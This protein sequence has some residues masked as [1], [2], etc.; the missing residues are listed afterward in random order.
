[1]SRPPLSLGRDPFQRSPRTPGSLGCHDAADPNLDLDLGD[2]PGS[3][4]HNDCAD[5]NQD[6]RYSFG[7]RRLHLHFV[8]IHGGLWDYDPDNLL[9]DDRLSPEFVEKAHRALKL[10]ITLYELRPIVHEAYRSPEESDRKHELYLKHKGGKAAPAWSSAHNYGLAMDV[11]LYDQRHHYIDNHVKGWYKLYTK[12]AKACSDFIW[13][14]PFD[15]ADHFEYHPNWPN[16][17]K[18]TLAAPARDW[19]MRAAVQNGKLTEYDAQAPEA[20]PNHGKT[21]R[22][23]IPINEIEWLPYFWW[24]AGAELGATAPPDTYLASNPRPV[25]A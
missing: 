3:L 14:E 7:V 4:G 5:P 16:P 13:G 9:D 1:M 11:W 8:R 24:A 19:A 12:L 10:A 22:D 2:T 25:Q 6:S 23:F 21:E 15:D 17:L 18:G 20:T